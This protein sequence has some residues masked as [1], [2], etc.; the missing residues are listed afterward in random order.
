[1][2]DT[3]NKYV[4]TEDASKHVHETVAW[5]VGL[6]LEVGQHVW[7]KV[8]AY[9][10]YVAHVASEALEPDLEVVQGPAGANGANGAN[11]TNGSDGAPGTPLGDVVWKGAWSGATAYVAGD[12]VTYS[13]RAYVCIQGHTNYV[14]PNASYWV[15]ISSGALAVR[16]EDPSGSKNGSN[17]VF[18]LAHV[19]QGGIDLYLNGLRLIEGAAFDYTISSQTITLTA[20]QFAPNVAKGDNLRVSYI[21]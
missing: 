12:G 14:P 19:P 2:V 10:V 6:S 16:G 21:Y 13:S 17:K 8:V 1:M 5:A 9:N 7:N 3:I 4:K 11:G 15:E 18:T 20:S